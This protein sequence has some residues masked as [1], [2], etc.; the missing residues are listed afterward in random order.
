MERYFGKSQSGNLIKD[1]SGVFVIHADA[2]AEI[3]KLKQEVEQ[4]K[5]ERDGKRWLAGERLGEEIAALRSKLAALDWRPITEADLPKVGDELLGM[6]DKVQ[7][8]YANEEAYDIERWKQTYW[9]HFRAIN[10]PEA[11]ND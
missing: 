3:D 2:Q 5:N 4:M 9:T 8:V 7:K 11:H 1:D 6:C 10:P